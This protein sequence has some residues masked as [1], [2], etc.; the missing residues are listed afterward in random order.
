MICVRSNLAKEF[1]PG[2]PKL[3]EREDIGRALATGRGGGAAGSCGEE[4]VPPYIDRFIRIALT[5]AMR[6]G[7]IRTLQAGRIDFSNRYP[8]GEPFEV[9]AR[10][11]VGKS[12]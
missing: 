5:S 10:Y 2:V 12:R 7:E 3:E 4:L 8:A 6:S 11:G 9:E 1:W